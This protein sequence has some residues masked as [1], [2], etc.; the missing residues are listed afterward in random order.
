MN[1]QHNLTNK[2]GPDN[3]SDK[4]TKFTPENEK[5]TG[6]III[7][8]TTALLRLFNADGSSSYINKAWI[9]FT[10]SAA[11]NNYSLTEN[12]HPDN[13]GDYKKAWQQATH[14]NKEFETSYQLLHRSG[15]YRWICEY[16]K[17]VY[18]AEGVCS[19]FLSTG[20]DVHQHKEG[21]KY[22]IKKW[23][24]I[25]GEAFHDLRGNI[26]IISGAS[27]L[28]ELIDKEADRESTLEMIH[29]NVGQMQTL[30]NE[31]LVQFEQQSN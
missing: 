18:C 3:L 16:T 27:G 7:E 31:L 13:S 6:S 12:M 20:I 4:N 1:Q 15:H 2:N 5:S 17:P 26:G 23:S 25:L 28:L 29:R 30:M 8:N 19:G 14:Q 24:A 22:F 21:E 11:T 10:G 9:D